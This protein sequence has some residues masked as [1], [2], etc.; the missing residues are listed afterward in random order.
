VGRGRLAQGA[1]VLL[2]RF[3]RGAFAQRADRIPLLKEK[4]D[5]ILAAS[6][7][8]RGS[9]TWRETRATFNNFRR[10]T[11]STPA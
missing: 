3:A 9:H 10:P 11:S 2:G 5:R 7:R 6:G 1:D 8:S 4:H